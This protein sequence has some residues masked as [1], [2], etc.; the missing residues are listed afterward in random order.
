MMKD[1]EVQIPESSSPAGHQMLSSSPL[2]Q[3]QE[4]GSN[5]NSS[6]NT[7]TSSLRERFTFKQVDVSKLSS[8]NVNSTEDDLAILSEEF[9]DFS[10]TLVQAVFKSNSFNI[11]LSR[12]RLNKIRTQ[13]TSWSWTSGKKPETTKDRLNSISSSS[14]AKSISAAATSKITLDKQK[15]S[16]FDRYSS[17]MNHSSK[18]NMMTDIVVDEESL[19]KLIK[20]DSAKSGKRRRL[21]RGDHLEEVK[22]SKTTQ[23]DVAKD[24]LFKKKK[25]TLMDDEEEGM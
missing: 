24:K 1:E 15:S 3:G 11:E 8:S 12:Q 13:R 21:V 16:I 4:S 10:P 2:K 22:K 20:S 9:N 14:N 25:E 5:G 19:S 23:L 18:R 6:G 7:T 17:V